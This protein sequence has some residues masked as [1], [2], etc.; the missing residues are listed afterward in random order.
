M[1]KFSFLGMDKEYKDSKVI[2]FGIPFDGT[3]SNRP[4]TR[5]A[6]N[7]VRLESFGIE[8]YSPLLDKDLEDLK[9]HDM[10]NITLSIGNTDK[11]IEEIEIICDNLLQDNKIPLGIG[12]EHLVT[13]PLISAFL[14]K[15]EDINIL[16]L[17]AHTDL[18]Q[19]F[20]NSKLSHATVMKRIFDLVGEN[21]IF[22]FG[23]RSGTKQEF[24]FAKENGIYTEKF[25]IDTVKEI[26]EKLKTK[27]VYV[28][29]DVDVLDPSIM[30]G[31]GTPE[32]GGITYKELEKFFVNLSQSSV[33]VVGAD[34]VELSP[35]YDSSNV[36]TATVCKI[37]REIAIILSK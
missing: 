8:T 26:L 1:N 32:S 9:I 23:I 5:F 34:I 37:L 12:G 24:D 7:A 15:Y 25:T 6:A 10:G 2:V 35:H 4:G 27:N 20:N 33:N 14:K 13:Y 36:S 22:Q 16:H 29:I 3:T 19:E 30:Q 28:T 17:D 11:V 31:T 18:R 21:R